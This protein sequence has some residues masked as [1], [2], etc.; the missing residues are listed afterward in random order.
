MSR[1]LRRSFP[2]LT[3]ALL[4]ISLMCVSGAVAKSE[5]DNAI[6]LVIKRFKKYG[7]RVTPLS[8]QCLSFQSD[9][10]D[11]KGADI[12]VTL[13]EIHNK[14]CG[15]DPNTAPRVSSF[16]VKGNEVFVEDPVTGELS[17]FDSSVNKKR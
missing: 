10:S 1:V 5:R 3:F 11:A 12:E 14:V 6:D 7:D 9:E 17:P 13:R 15:G 8:L 2:Q 16:T 4:T